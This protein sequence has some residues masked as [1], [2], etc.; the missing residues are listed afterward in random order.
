MTKIIT[1]TKIEN[2]F[3]ILIFLSGY[4]ININCGFCKF[5]FLEH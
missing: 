5:L 3:R 1:L 4:K 2:I